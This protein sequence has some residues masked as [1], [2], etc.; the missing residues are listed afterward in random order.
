MGTRS[1]IVTPAFS[2]SVHNDSGT[3]KL[4]AVQGLYSMVNH[5]EH[6]TY[7]VEITI[8]IKTAVLLR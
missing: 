7:D 4:N 3:F 8:I 1:R 5:L 2:A 6:L